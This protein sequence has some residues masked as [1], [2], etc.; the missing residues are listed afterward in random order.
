M[1]LLHA[2]FKDHFTHAFWG[3]AK[4]R[5]A[6]CASPWFSAAIQRSLLKISIMLLLFP[7]EQFVH[8]CD[9]SLL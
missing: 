3:G 1:M 2:A 4:A 9:S 7:S 5:S 8:D 6:G